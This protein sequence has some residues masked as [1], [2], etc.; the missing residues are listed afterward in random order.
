MKHAWNI[1]KHR[2]K[3]YEVRVNQIKKSGRKRVRDKFE[4]KIIMLKFLLRGQ[5]A[6]DDEHMDILF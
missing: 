1:S 3:K 4:K 2:V 5:K 6:Y